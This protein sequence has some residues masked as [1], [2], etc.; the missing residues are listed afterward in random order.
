MKNNG[1]KKNM[2]LSINDRKKLTNTCNSTVI[3]TKNY[4]NFCL[5]CFWLN[6]NLLRDLYLK[7]DFIV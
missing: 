7:N 3:R 5:L 2:F 1:K 6:K 4:D